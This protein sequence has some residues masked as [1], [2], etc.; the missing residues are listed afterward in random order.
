MAKQYFNF[1]ENINLI[2]S[3]KYTEVKNELL[4]IYKILKN[5]FEETTD[6]LR[7]NKTKNKGFLEEFLHK[8][9]EIIERKNKS[10]I[11]SIIRKLE[12]EKEIRNLEYEGISVWSFFAIN[13]RIAALELIKKD[14]PQSMIN[15]QLINVWYEK[16][17]NVLKKSF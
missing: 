9:K 7:L 3:S 13:F 17:S 8:R 16:T 14:S 15:Q 1:F 12:S 11:H 10:P 6:F 5:K 4:T 2:N